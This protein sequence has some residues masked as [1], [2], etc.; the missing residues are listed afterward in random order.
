MFIAIT[1]E[2]CILS[3]E[4]YYTINKFE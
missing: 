3:T 1:A 4:R 2:D